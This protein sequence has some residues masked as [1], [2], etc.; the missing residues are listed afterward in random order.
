MLLKLD[1]V[2]IESNTGETIADDHIHVS[3]GAI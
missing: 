1:V 2:R 3:L